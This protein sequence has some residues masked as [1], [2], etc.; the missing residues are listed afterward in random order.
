MFTPTPNTVLKSPNVRAKSDGLQPW[1]KEGQNVLCD[2]GILEMP[3][4]LFLIF[5]YS[6]QLH[7][8]RKEEEEVIS[9]PNVA[10]KTLLPFNKR[11]FLFFL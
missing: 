8:P 5:I 10:N 7:S 9:T 1:W 6:P 11:D 4:F 2:P 3:N